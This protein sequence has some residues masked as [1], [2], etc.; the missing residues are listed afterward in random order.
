MKEAVHT[1]FRKDLD[2]F[3][4]QSTGSTGRLNLD[5]K[6]LKIKFSI[7]EPYFYKNVLKRILKVNISKHIK[8]L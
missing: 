7:L 4:G 5:H 2:K 1:I 8:P 3:Q 6:W